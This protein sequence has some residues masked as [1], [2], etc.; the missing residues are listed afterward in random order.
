MAPNTKRVFYVNAVSAPIYLEI[1][2]KRPDIHIDKLVNDSP[3]AEAE[4]I[5]A[6]AHAFQ[7]GSS[8][9]ELAMKYQGYAPLFHRCPNLLVLSTNGA[10][11]DT[12]N[13]ADAT[14]AGVAVVNQAGGNKEGVAEHV[15]A[16]MLTLSK[17]IPMADK[18]MRRGSDY[19]RPDFMG[20][21]VQGRTIG[22]VGIGHV[23]GRVAELCRGLFQ[24]RVLAYDPYLT[25]E[26]IAAKGAE[27]VATLDELLGQADYVSIN[28]PHTA[29]TRGLMGAAQF[30]LMQP[31]AYFISTARGGIHDEAALAAAL[32]AKQVAGAGLDVWEDEPP[33]S[34]HPLL[35]FDNVVASP[36]NAGITRQSRHNIARIAAEQMLDILDGKKPPRLLN[37]EVWPVYRERFARILGMT[38]EA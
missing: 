15:M 8:R 3:D 19:K 4:P 16:L 37:P 5:L 21:D 38:P 2:C 22:I 26:Q 28:C 27:K 1:L 6:H 7:L 25:A 20:D 11:F 12:V 36:H 29:E 14:A 17:R 34:D 23:G 9:Q 24:M 18:A 30:A 13:L 35:K 10:G 31:H 32:T 33:P